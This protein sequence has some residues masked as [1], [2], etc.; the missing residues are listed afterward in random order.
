MKLMR[1][2]AW[3]RALGFLILVWLLF[4]LVAVGLLK[5]EPDYQTTQRMTRALKEL[6]VLHQ[7]RLELDQLL[8]QYTAG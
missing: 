5:H 8:K 2:V 3:G 1:Q 6:K 4:L 7:Q